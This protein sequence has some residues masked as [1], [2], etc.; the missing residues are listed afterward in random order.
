MRWEC[1]GLDK[2]VLQDISHSRKEGLGSGG[3]GV[4]AL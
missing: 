4:C 2:E 1:D 3:Q